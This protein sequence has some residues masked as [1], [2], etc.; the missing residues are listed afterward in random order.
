ML[1][2]TG[3]QGQSQQLYEQTSEL[4]GTAGHPIRALALAAVSDSYMRAT[5]DG[6]KQGVGIGKLRSG[7][8][9]ALDPSKSPPRAQ[10]R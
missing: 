5:H 4:S 8:C 1:V 6:L 7:R 3:K 2:P 9:G 10:R